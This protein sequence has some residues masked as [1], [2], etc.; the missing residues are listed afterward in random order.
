[1]KPKPNWN[2]INGEAKPWLDASDNFAKYIIKRKAWLSKRELEIVEL[3]SL[4]CSLKQ[5]AGILRLTEGTVKVYSARMRKKT[6]C[7]T[8][9][10]LV[11]EYVTRKLTYGDG[12]N[13]TKNTK[14]SYQR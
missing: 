2:L 12:K 8:T 13:A 9:C 3:L 7:K 1:M 11:A 14:Q 6:N 4:G 10:Q 5:V